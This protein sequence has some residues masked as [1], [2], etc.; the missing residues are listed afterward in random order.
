MLADAGIGWCGSVGG[1]RVE[2][3]VEVK[4]RVVLGVSKALRLVDMLSSI[5]DRDRR[6][7]SR[8]T[9]VLKQ[10]CGVSGGSCVG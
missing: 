4:G 8:R 7:K 5:V 10:N 6:R 2:V 9:R 3:E 1:E